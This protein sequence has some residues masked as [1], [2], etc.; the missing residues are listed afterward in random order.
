MGTPS[1]CR[2]PAGGA[3]GLRSAEEQLWLGRLSQC[4]AVHLIASVDHVSSALLWD[5]RSAA[6]FRWCWHEVTTYAPYTAETADTPPLL[7]GGRGG[8]WAAAGRGVAVYPGAL[9]ALLG[10][11]RRALGL[12]CLAGIGTPCWDL[13]PGRLPPT[14]PTPPHP[15]PTHPP[16]RAQ[17]HSRCPPGAAQPACSTPWS[18]AR[19]P[20][21]YS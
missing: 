21:S 15:A 12:Q 9:R 19:A 2:R 4:P 3:A 7:T 20:C 10:L 14:P 8:Q 11:G 17:A 1:S 5:K 18:A 6:L 16:T 13:R